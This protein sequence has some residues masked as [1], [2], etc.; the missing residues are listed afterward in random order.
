MRR[1]LKMWFVAFALAVTSGCDDG[2]VDP[3]GAPEA[4]F[5]IANSFGPAPL[6]ASFT[7]LSTGEF[8]SSA[9][10]FGDGES[11]SS[12]SPSHTYNSPGIYTV[13]L[14][15]S[16]AQGS[17]TKTKRESVKVTAPPE[18]NFSGTPTSGDAPLSVSFTNQ[19]TGTFSSSAWSFGDGAT[20][21]SS[22]PSHTY[23]NPGTYSVSLTVSG[24][25]GPD[26][27]TKSAYVTVTPVTEIVQISGGYFGG[28][29]P[30][31][32]AGDRDFQGH[33]PYIR[34]HARLEPV[35]VGVSHPEVRL[36]VDFS[37]RETVSD[38]TSA[39]GRWAWTLY[40][41]SSGWTFDGF[42]PFLDASGTDFSYTDVSRI[43]DVFT[44]SEPEFVSSATIIGDTDGNDVGN[45]T[46]DDTRIVRIDYRS[47]RVRLR[48]L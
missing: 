47:V 33:G 41:V 48:K 1:R 46:T 21:S 39:S 45:C 19:S 24:V 34:V 37:A 36:I 14:T 27:E 25:Q 35:N 12:S 38:Y 8:S 2:I 29:C 5:S 18:A 44:F 43:P 26:T 42:Y 11:S 13:S 6:T 3:D 17:D 28:Y 4:N 31:W 30:T 9:W 7:N 22:N 40:T 10:S 20:S 15:V 32:N 23:S 16:G